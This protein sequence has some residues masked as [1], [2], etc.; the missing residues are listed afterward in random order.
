M[1]TRRPSAPRLVA[2]R[3][4][5]VPPDQRLDLLQRGREVAGVVDQRPTVLEDQAVVVRHLLGPDEVAQP[6]LG[7]VQAALAGDRVHHPLHHEAA[8]RPA[9]APVGRDE[10]GVGVEA[11]ELDPVGPGLVRA[12]QL[13]RGDDRHDQPVRRVGAV[14]VPEL[15]PT[16]R[17]AR[18]SSSY[19][20]ST[21]C[22]WPRSCADEMKCSRRSST[23]FTGRPSRIAAHGTRISSGHGCTI[24]TPKPPPTSGVTTSTRST[25][26]LELGG[27][28]LPDAGR[29]L[30]RGVHE[31]RLVV[32]V[33]ARHHAL[34]L[35]RHRGTAFDGQRQGLAV[36]GRGD[37]GGR[38]TGLLDLYGAT[39]AGYVV[40]HERLSCSRR[41]RRR[42]Q[43]AGSR[44]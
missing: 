29:G 3:L 39:V 41:A 32:R 35:H 25:G 4:E 14:V 11:V 43:A 27:D 21:S 8:L 10:H 23:H 16:A 38:V 7:A 24:L 1:P 30:R 34:A 42:R 9:G 26:R 40:V 22:N 18:P 2:V 19:P 15:A 33:P 37:G 44:S 36:R 28:R 13:G 12:E 20:T 31:Q 17:A 5:V 6:D